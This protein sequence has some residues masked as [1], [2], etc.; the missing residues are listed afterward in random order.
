M[1]KS[2]LVLV[3]L[4]VV[5]MTACLNPGAA[6]PT[7]L[8]DATVLPDGGDTPVSSDGPAI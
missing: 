5:G 4:V 8:P 3:L 7:P 6:A 2:L 1:K